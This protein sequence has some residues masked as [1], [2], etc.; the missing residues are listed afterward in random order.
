VG[1][2]L[3]QLETI[4]NISLSSSSSFFFFGHDIQR[5]GNQVNQIS[6]PS[7]PRLRHVCAGQGGQATARRTQRRS[8]LFT[9]SFVKFVDRLF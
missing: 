3:R 8:Y 1:K 5:S 9:I 2:E 6:R 4:L 7:S